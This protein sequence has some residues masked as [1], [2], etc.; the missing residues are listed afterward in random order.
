MDRRIKVVQK[1]WIDDLK[2]PASFFSSHDRR[3]R[4]HTCH[5][6]QE[7]TSWDCHV[8]TIAIAIE[9]WNKI[10]TSVIKL[11]PYILN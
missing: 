5:V 1:E 11:I 8:S 6:Y 3:R 7:Y 2:K 10:E 4:A 9:F